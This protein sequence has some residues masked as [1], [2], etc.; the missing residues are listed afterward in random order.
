[1][2]GKWMPAGA[3]VHMGTR[4]VDT[5]ADLDPPADAH[6]SHSSLR[7]TFLGLTARANGLRHLYDYDIESFV[8]S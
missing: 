1:M 2:L 7:V 6:V 8:R 3:E 5:S 4:A